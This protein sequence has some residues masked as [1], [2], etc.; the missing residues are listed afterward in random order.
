MGDLTEFQSSIAVEIVDDGGLNAV[1]VNTTTP[2][3]GDAALTVR[4]VVRGQA[5]MAA[6][7]PVT[8]ASNQASIPVVISAGNTPPAAVPPFTDNFKVFDH[9]FVSGD[10]GLLWYTQAT[11]GGTTAFS[12][13]D[14]S[15]SLTT[16]TTSA[17]QVIRQ[18]QRILNQGGTTMTYLITALMGALKANVRQRIG[19]FSSLNG[20]FFEQDGTNLKIVTRTSVSGSVVDTAVNQSSWNIDKLNG[21]GSS[22][23]T[24]DTSKVNNYVICYTA[25][26]VKFGI[27]INWTLYFCHQ[28]AG[29]NT[30]TAPLFENTNLPVRLELTNTAAAASS[31]SMKHYT[32]SVYANGGT[33]PFGINR[34][35]DLGIT[36]KAIAATLTP[37]LSIRL[38]SANIYNTLQ[39]LALNLNLTSSQVLSTQLIFNGTLTTP[40]WTALAGTNTMTEYDTVAT[41]VTGGDIIFSSYTDGTGNGTTGNLPIDT[42][43]LLFL[44][45]S[46]SDN[47][48]GTSSGANTTT[49]LN[50]TT[51]VWATSQWVGKTVKITGGTGS[52]QERVITSNTATQLVIT[53]IWTTTPNA[54]STYTINSSDL[55][56]F[57]GIKTGGTSPTGYAAI[58]FREYF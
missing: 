1:K 34:A 35:V 52:G 58:T 29:P 14:Y 21:S 12:S 40:T 53:T 13:V 31:T 45:S 39:V 10:N 44:S 20:A 33:I 42:G 57:A 46:I 3:S 16:T 26:S 22:G 15:L 55:V 9:K 49:T 19:F 54:T 56:T 17:S 2:G 5:T 25:N 48:S 43:S 51:K 36:G 18:S 4:E 37:L 41:A 30:L 7:I 32:T 11:T 47:I 38:S 23:I 8:M 24:L 27:I 28:V 50:D 6:S